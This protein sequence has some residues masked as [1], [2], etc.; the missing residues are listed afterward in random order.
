MWNKMI[1]EKAG[2]ERQ[3]SK[4]GFQRRSMPAAWREFLWFQF[5][6]QSVFKGGR[7]YLENSKL[8]EAQTGLK[9][10]SR[11]PGHAAGAHWLGNFEGLWHCEEHVK[12]MFFLQWQARVDW[13][14]EHNTLFLRW[15]A[16]VEWLDDEQNTFF[17]LTGQEESHCAGCRVPG[18][19]CH[20]E[21]SFFLQSVLKR[22]QNSSNPLRHPAGRQ[23]AGRALVDAAAAYLQ[24]AHACSRAPGSFAGTTPVKQHQQHI[25]TDRQAAQ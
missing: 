24:P 18:L 12:T 25:P 19:P 15:Q 8:A 17:A 3:N 4:K 16:R 7:P 14:N 9:V 13:Q 11:N 22:L 6:C 20:R 1:E 5:E 21:A 23:A 10:T 2:F